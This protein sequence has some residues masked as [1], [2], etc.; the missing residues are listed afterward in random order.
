[1]SCDILGVKMFDDH[2]R[3]AITQMKSHRVAWTTYE[4]SIVSLRS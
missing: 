1:M 4:D 3:N 2:D